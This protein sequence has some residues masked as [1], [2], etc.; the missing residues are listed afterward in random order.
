MANYRSIFFTSILLTSF[1]LANQGLCDT[2]RALRL[3]NTTLEKINQSN[4]TNVSTNSVCMPL[5]GELPFEKKEL[6][7]YMCN[8]KLTTDDTALKKKLEERD[9]GRYFAPSTIDD[10]IS[11]FRGYTKFNES[12]PE[13]FNVKLEDEWKL[14]N[15]NMKS[16]PCQYRVKK[17]SETNFQQM[18]F[19]NVSFIGSSHFSGKKGEKLTN[20]QNDLKIKL[21]DVKPDVLLI[22]GKDFGKPIDC[23]AVM[24][25]ALTKDNEFTSEMRSTIK[26][27]F[28]NKI[29]LV[30]ADNQEIDEED[31]SFMK[32]NQ[33]ATNNMKETYTFLETLHIYHGLL[34]N[35]DPN[36]IK[37]ALEQSNNSM[38]EEEF[39]KYYSKLNKRE[40]PENPD[41]IQQ[42]FC[43][44][45]VA[46]NERKSNRMADAQNEIRNQSLVK[47][48]QISS[49]KFKNPAVIYG[50]GHLGQI[51]ETLEEHLGKPTNINFES[52]C[53]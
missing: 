49:M 45:I 28:W 30:P 3:A 8:T 23:I 10:F 6:I 9:A 36:A 48:I 31:S 39:K 12:I 22:E 5:N 50:S 2:K 40:L 26:Y 32:D 52:D 17:N 1:F 53:K 29:P 15:Q 37:V 27:G 13:M 47:A 46:K 4:S 21:A 24:T 42:D 33:K 20:A 51:G 16:Y 38:T 41:E 11:S 7:D 44:S 43:P 18:N 35:N 14:K 34:K 19:Q 25:D